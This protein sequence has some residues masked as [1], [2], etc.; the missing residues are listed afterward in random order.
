MPSERPADLQGP[1]A[2]I[3]R[4]R[5]IDRLEAS[6]GGGVGRDLEVLEA[7]CAICWNAGAATVPP[8][9]V[10]GSSR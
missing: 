1:S 4:S 10:L 9:I 3:S 8:Q 6:S 7:K 5:S 2:L